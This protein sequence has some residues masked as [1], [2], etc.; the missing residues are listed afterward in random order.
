[1]RNICSTFI[2][3]LALF[4]FAYPILIEAFFNSTKVFLDVYY[5]N[6]S[7]WVSLLSNTGFLALAAFD[8]LISKK[9][10]SFEKGMVALIVIGGIF[11]IFIFLISHLAFVNKISNY[12]ILTYPNLCWILHLL[13]LAT[14][15][16]IKYLTLQDG[17]VSEQSTA[18]GVSKE[19]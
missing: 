19:H 4:I 2:W 17:M 12:P 10:M 13:F 16:L 8:Y 5:E 18:V 9:D 3:I 6:Q 11:V 15:S 1:M 7:Q 14:I